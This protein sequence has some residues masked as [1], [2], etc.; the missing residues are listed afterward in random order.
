MTLKASAEKGAFGSGSR[1]TSSSVPG[2]VPAAGCTSSGD[3]SRSM[4][5]SSSGWTPLFLNEE[6]QSTGVMA[7]ARTAVRIAARRRSFEISSPS[8]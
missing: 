5:A 7:I 6:P 1:T 8:R 3:G 2:M 4:T